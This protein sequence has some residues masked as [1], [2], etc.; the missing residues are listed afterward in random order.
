MEVKVG[1][2][3][4]FFAKVGVVALKLEQPLAVGDTIKIKKY[5]GE[6]VEKVTSMQ[7]EHQPVS[8][9]KAGDSVGIK[10]TGR[11]HKGNVVYKVVE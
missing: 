11:A 7:I 6:L 4:D 9:A 8:A 1:V 5:D 2:V 3:E 10:I